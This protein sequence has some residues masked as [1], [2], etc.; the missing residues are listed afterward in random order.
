MGKHHPVSVNGR[1]DPQL[2]GIDNQ[3]VGVATRGDGMMMAVDPVGGPGAVAGDGAARHTGAV[4]PRPVLMGRLGS[5][6]RVTVVSGAAGSRKTVLLRSWIGGADL[7]GRTAWVDAGRYVRDPQ[8]FWLSVVGALRSTGPGSELV[9]AVS[10]APDVDG[11]ALVERLLDDLAPLEKRLWLVVDDVQTLRSAFPAL[12]ARA[13]GD[14]TVLTGVLADQAALY[15]VLAEAE[16]LGLEL[17]E[18][19]RLPPDE[20]REPPS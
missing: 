19:R 5:P 7:A 18:V 2:Q 15:G 6:A 14:D 20:P 3:W 17:L 12:R 13:H 8:S 9:R 4:V 11:W 10:A 16:A 1:S